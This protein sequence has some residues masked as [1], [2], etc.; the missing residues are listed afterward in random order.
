MN[1]G[2]PEKSAA[3][4]FTDNMVG[5]VKQMQVVLESALKVEGVRVFVIGDAVDSESNR[6]MEAST[7]PDAEA[8][9]QKRMWW[10]EHELDDDGVNHIAMRRWANTSS[11]LAGHVATTCDPLLLCV[12][13]FYSSR[14][15]SF[16]L[17]AL[18]CS[19]SPPPLPL[20]PSPPSLFP[21]SLQNR[22]VQ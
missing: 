1:P 5:V 10:V 6:E 15:S 21:P 7:D 12:F 14:L 22:R 4:E 16:P 8:S 2:S 19:F 13:L 11:A 3:P 18:L 20:T 17:R 9:V